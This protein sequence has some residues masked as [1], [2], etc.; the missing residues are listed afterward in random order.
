MILASASMDNIVAIVCFGLLSGF[1]FST[2]SLTMTI[3]QGPLEILIGIGTGL[4]W[5]FFIGIL[6]QDDSKKK[7]RNSRKLR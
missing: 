2:K 6:F 3:L 5:G 1:I 7:V 4:S